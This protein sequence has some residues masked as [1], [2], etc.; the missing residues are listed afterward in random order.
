M[1]RSAFDCVHYSFCTFCRCLLDDVYILIYDIV[2]AANKNLTDYWTNLQCDLN[3]NLQALIKWY[4]DIVW[5]SIT[6]IIPQHLQ[7]IGKSKVL[8]KNCLEF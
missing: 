2:I 7:F 6:F 5:R 3:E 4:P 1:L 8:Y